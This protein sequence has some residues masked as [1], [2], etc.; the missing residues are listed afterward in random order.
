[1]EKLREKVTGAD[2][3][4]GDQ[5]RKKGDGQNEITQRFSGPQHTSVNVERVRK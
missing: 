4:T 1:M 5:L 3:W 2:N